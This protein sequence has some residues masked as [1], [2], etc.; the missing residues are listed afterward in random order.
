MEIIGTM[1]YQPLSGGFWGLIGLDGQQWRLK[2]TPLAIQVNG[3]KVK[4]KAILLPNGPS[5]FMW[6][7]PI[8]VLSFELYNP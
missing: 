4:V 6:G 3:L 2:E 7:K 1:Q 8:Q 5:I